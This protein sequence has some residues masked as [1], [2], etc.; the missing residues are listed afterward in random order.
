MS[1]TGTTTAATN[2]ARNAA[3][4]LVADLFKKLEKV[5]KLIWKPTDNQAIIQHLVTTPGFNYEDWTAK[6]PKEWKGIAFVNTKGKKGETHVAK[7]RSIAF[8]SMDEVFADATMKGI[9][10]DR[11]IGMLTRAASDPEAEEAAFSTLNGPW[12]EEDK[13]AYTFQAQAWVQLFIDR[14]SDK[15]G[16][17][18]AL[19]TKT[20]R[21]ALE[22][23]EYAKSHFPGIGNW[24]KVLNSMKLKA[25]SNGFSTALFDHWI[26]TRDI[27]ADAKKITVDLDDSTEALL[28][29]LGPTKQAA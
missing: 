28:A 2:V 18:K 3:A 27:V 16:M 5:G 21:L 25:Q 8:P 1:Q 12:A 23:D 10:F 9:L 13:G 4:T 15:K 26:A 24:D 17:E 20:F 7:T 6:A 14:S 11:Y 29:S 22:S 19:N